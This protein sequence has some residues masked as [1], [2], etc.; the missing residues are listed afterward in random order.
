M[1][2]RIEDRKMYMEY[3][4][5]WEKFITKDGQKLD[6]II[7]EAKAKIKRIGKCKGSSRGQMQPTS[8]HASRH[9]IHELW[10]YCTNARIHAQYP[11]TILLGELVHLCWDT[12]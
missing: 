10:T 6:S 7:E 9:T 8:G 11:L 12:D 2:V 5:G 3:G 4:N 1:H